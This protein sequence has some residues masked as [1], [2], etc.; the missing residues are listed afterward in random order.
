MHGDEIVGRELL[1]QLVQYLCD[2][3]GRVDIVTQLINKTR[4]HIM[5]TVNPDGY[6][7]ALKYHMEGRKN[8]NGIDLNRNFPSKFNI[9]D[10]T[11]G[12]IQPET[13]AII[14]WSK[15]YP[16]V[17]SANLHGGAM[18]A[19][20]PYD[21]NLQSQTKFSPSPDEETFKMLSKAYSEAHLKMYK[22]NFCNE[23]FEDGITNGAQWYPS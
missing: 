19:N 10:Q 1:V 22:G 4:I 14:Q 15:Q 9:T 5:P 8:A 23:R 7:E 13:S 17:L 12:T 18:V 2:N 16:F 3:Y 6:A 11:S 20:Y 21:T